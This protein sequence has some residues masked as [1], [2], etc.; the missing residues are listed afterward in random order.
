MTE[1]K[2]HEKLMGSAFE[3]I[4]VC[5]KQSEADIFL[6][7]GLAEI[8]RIEQLL[9]EFKEDSVTTLLN[10]EA[11]KNAVK[12]P[13]EVYQLLQRCIHI[14]QFTQG[15]FDITVGPLKKLYNFKNQ[16]FTFPD[17]YQLQKTLPKVGFS[18]ILLQNN[19]KVLLSQKGMHLSFASI[20]KGY[21][22]DCV[23]KLWLKNGLQGG[24]INAS[25]DLT[26]IGKRADLSTWKVGIAHP[27]D[28]KKILAYIPAEKESV[29]T[30]GDYEQFF[31]KDGIR[32]SHNINPKTGK[33]LTGIK[34]VSVVS[35][36]AELSDALA[37]AVYVMGVEVGIH[38]INQLPE[39]H[40]LIV[41]DQ[42]KVFHSKN[43]I[44]EYANA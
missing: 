36:G 5:E 7:D 44:F 40:C 32:Y 1:F 22:A 37:T 10:N 35:P 9:S 25:G 16:D 24:I 30:S 31:I 23:R 20:G 21:A 6:Q 8:S 4:V 43:I 33:P 39:T 27:D 15:A 38:F 19:H 29:A 13:E 41:D 12:I 14:S 17:Y 42:N 28:P 11:G 18:R 26:V 34:S 2:I 3:L